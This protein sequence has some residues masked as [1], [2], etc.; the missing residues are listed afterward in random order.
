MQKT[1]RSNGVRE[2]ETEEK[3]GNNIETMHSRALRRNVR[4]AHPDAGFR[5]EGDPSRKVQKRYCGFD[6][7]KEDFLRDKVL[8]RASQPERKEG[9][10]AVFR[11]NLSDPFRRDGSSFRRKNRSRLRRQRR[12][13]V[14]Q[15]IRLR[16]RR[17]DSSGKRMERSGRLQRIH[18]KTLRSFSGEVFRK[19]AEISCKKRRDNE[20]VL[21]RARFPR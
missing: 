1:F 14:F 4:S 21:L 19:D 10:P 13:V 17:K 8:R 20:H 5:A 3:R 6:D 18:R 2:A 7:Y 11:R 15:R 16:Q 12:L 9:I